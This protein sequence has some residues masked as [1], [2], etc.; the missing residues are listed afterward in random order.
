MR[1]AYE[2]I[3]NWF[4]AF[5]KGDF[6]TLFSLMDED[7]RWKNCDVTQGGNDVIPWIGTYRG[8]YQ[9]KKTFEIYAKHS[10]PLGASIG[11]IFVDGDTAFVH[12]QEDNQVIDTGKNY[13]ANVTYQ[14]RVRNGKV[15]E[16]EAFWDSSSAILAFNGSMAPSSRLEFMSFDDILAECG[17]SGGEALKPLVTQKL[18]QKREKSMTLLMLASGNGVEWLVDALICNGADVNAADS[19]AGASPIHKACQ[20]GHLAVLKKLLDA[21][22]FIDATVHTTGHSPLMESIWYKSVEC[23]EYLLSKN[24]NYGIRTNYGFTIDDHIGYALKVNGNP[25]EREKLRRIKDALDERR[26]ADETRKNGALIRAVSR[27]D[28]DGVKAALGAGEDIEAKFPICDTLDDGSTPLLISS[29]LNQLEVVE[30][31]LKGNADVNA[32]EP[33]FAAAPLHKATYNGNLQA[34]RTLLGQRGV[35]VDAVGATNGYTPLHDALWHGFGECA[36]ALIDR[37]ARL[38]IRGHDGKLPLNIAEEV[39]GADSAIANRI[40]GVMGGA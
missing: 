15:F 31:L 40:R 36:D 37:G 19:K 6:D 30:T 17:A 2:V 12:A 27:N 10:K 26:K 20:G 13:R 21:G 14:M 24:A 33:V 22:A 34:L 8:V 35:N 23:A 7:I 38:D 11:E 29:R 18:A 32:V 4:E 1:A 3:E 25:A 9:V 39:F 28:A 5:R 16:W